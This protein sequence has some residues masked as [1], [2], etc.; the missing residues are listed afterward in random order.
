LPIGAIAGGAGGGVLLIV[1]L[2]L[3][4]IFLRRSKNAKKAAAEAAANTVE[5]ILKP[6]LDGY[7]RTPKLYDTTPEVDIHSGGK[8]FVPGQQAVEMGESGR[9]S[10]VYEMPA[11]E[12]AVEMPSAGNSR[13][14][15]RGRTSLG[16]PSPSSSPDIPTEATMFLNRQHRTGTSLASPVSGVRSV[17]PA[18]PASPMS[19]GTSLVS[20]ASLTRVERP[21]ARGPRSATSVVS[22]S[23]LVYMNR[24]PV[25][26][27][28]IQP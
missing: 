17:S 27:L 3:L 10:P 6:E 25:D 7:E 9:N 28:W 2:S 11:V 20:P 12:V 23:S 16:L 26:E 4:F 15:S 22:S 21:D 14:K 19:V 24:P 5:P 13:R 8:N 18:S 1:C